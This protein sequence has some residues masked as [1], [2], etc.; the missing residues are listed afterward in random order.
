M[1]KGN[2][3]SFLSGSSASLPEY[4]IP[5]ALDVRLGMDLERGGEGQ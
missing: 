4:F 5:E 3:G 1:L 2:Y